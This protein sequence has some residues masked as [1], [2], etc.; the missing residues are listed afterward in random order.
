MRRAVL[1]FLVAC[2]SD[3]APPDARPDVLQPRCD[4]AMPFA[5]PEPVGGLNSPN[6]DVSARLSADEL[7]VAFSR[8]TAAG[9][10]FYDMYSATRTARDL[11]F[12]PPTL[13]ATVNSVNSETW[14]TL[15]PSGL[16]LAFESDRSTGKA[17]IYTS[18]RATIADKFSAPTAAAALMDNEHHPYLATDRALYF[19]SALRTGGQGKLDIWRSEIDATGVISE[20]TTVLGGINTPEDEVTPTLTEDELRMFF[21]RTVGTELDIY[22]ASRSST[23]DGFG[24]ATAVPGLAEPGINEIPTWISPDGCSLYVEIANAANGMGGSDLFVA[25]RGTP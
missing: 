5:A 20:P 13:L 3:P 23:S 12:D 10:G 25:R 6:D 17:H 11:P 2:G 19:S 8:R 9:S 16:L 4:P 21:R 24:A 18:V 14:P 1:V 22:T 7:T 15:S